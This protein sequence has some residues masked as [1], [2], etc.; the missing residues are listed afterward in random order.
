MDTEGLLELYDPGIEFQ[1]LTG[2]R[3]ESGGYIGH[4]VVREYFAEIVDVW[5]ELH[6]YAD[7]VARSATTW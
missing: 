3:V 2:T 7:D 5:E 1:P 4:A 6:P